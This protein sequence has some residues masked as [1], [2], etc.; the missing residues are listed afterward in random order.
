MVID[1][2]QQPM[3]NKRTPRPAL[4]SDPTGKHKGL[5][6]SSPSNELA[7]GQAPSGPVDAGDLQVSD[8]LESLPFYV[9]LIDE[10][11]RILQANRAVQAQLGLKPEAVIGQYCPKII[12]GLDQPWH[13]CPLEEAV[14]KG[15]AVEREALDQQSGLWI[16]SAVYP[17]GK[18]T[19]EGKRIFFHM[20]S[21]ITAHKQA[22]EE[23]RNSRERLHTLSAYLESVREEERIT[24]AREIHDELGQALTALKIDMSWLIQK[25]PQKPEILVEKAWGMYDDID[26]AIQTVKRI[27]TELRPGALDDLG[28]SAAIEW[29]A[30]EFTRRTSIKCRFTSSP[31]DIVLDRDRS[32]AI[33]RICQEALTNVVRHA[34]ATRVNISLKGERVRVVVRVRD[35]GKGITLQQISSPRAFGIL[36]MQERAR[37]M[38]GDVK[39]SG[40]PGKGTTVTVNIPTVGGENLN[41]ESIDL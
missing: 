25:L 16:R 20:V 24:M 41:A 31:Q 26:G 19:R 9:L 13:A 22:E 28:L 5:T 17:T 23:L 12:H 7:A 33:F 35:N 36:G 14:E 21:D 34:E 38:G 37:F 1:A 4:R 8:I 32:T 39:I 3:K 11:H 30:R 18:F 40:A 6:R 29:Q 10:D 2:V 27:A 15:Q